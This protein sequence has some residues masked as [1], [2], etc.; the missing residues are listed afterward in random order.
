MSLLIIKFLKTVPQKKKE[1]LEK[2]MPNPSQK[3]F[4]ENYPSQKMPNLPNL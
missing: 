1:G 4:L 3:L 2:K